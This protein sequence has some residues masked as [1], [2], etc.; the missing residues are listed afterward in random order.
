[1]TLMINFSWSIYVN[2]YFKCSTFN[3]QD[4]D[5]V[6]HVCEKYVEIEWERLRHESKVNKGL[7][8]LK[9]ATYTNKRSPS[10]SMSQWIGILKC[11]E[12][13]YREVRMTLSGCKEILKPL[14]VE[15]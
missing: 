11:L 1:M 4:I 7:N 9:V 13:F 5:N 10:F 6:L 14:V 12:Q 2:I 15:S 3:I 8:E